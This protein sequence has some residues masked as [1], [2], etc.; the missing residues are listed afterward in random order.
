LVPTI[1][2]T[3]SAQHKSPKESPRGFVGVTL[4]PCGI[5]PGMVEETFAST[6][7][8]RAKN[9][10]LDPP[11]IVAVRT[12]VEAVQLLAAR[13]YLAGYDVEVVHGRLRRDH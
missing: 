7:T 13:L 9:S 1:F 10:K 8:V 5:I 3:L 4:V 6:H 12:S 2:L 11:E